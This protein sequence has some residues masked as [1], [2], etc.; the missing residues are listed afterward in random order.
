[1]GMFDWVNFECKCPNCGSE[2]SGFQSKD[3]GCDIELV[4][5]KD[6]NHFYTDCIKCGSWIEFNRKR[7]NSIKSFIG[8]F[9]L[10]HSIREF[11]PIVI[12]A[13]SEEN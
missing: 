8:T 10:K 11:T 13:K 1:M 12:N 7:N 9:T 3:S 2:V 4:E 5:I 6:V